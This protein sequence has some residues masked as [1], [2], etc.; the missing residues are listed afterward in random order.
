MRWVFGPA[1]LT[2]PPSPIKGRSTLPLLAA[3]FLRTGNDNMTNY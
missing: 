3:G 1:Y 2:E